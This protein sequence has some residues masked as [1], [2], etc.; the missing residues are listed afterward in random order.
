MQV[1]TSLFNCVADEV[2][3][4]SGIV[5]EDI[6]DDFFRPVSGKDSGEKTL[7]IAGPSDNA[8]HGMYWEHLTSS[9]TKTA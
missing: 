3:S 6:Q 5:A 7:P 1:G 4:Q 9:D 8:R 2:R